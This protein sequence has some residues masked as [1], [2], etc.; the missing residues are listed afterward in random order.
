MTEQT[1]KL[2][3]S[4]TGNYWQIINGKRVYFNKEKKQ[5][6]EA[7]FLQSENAKINK[8]GKIQSNKIYIK[9]STSG[10]YYTIENG[11]R[12]YFAANGNEIKESYF[13]QQEGVKKNEKGQLVKVKKESV[14]AKSAK[15]IAKNLKK[16][17]DGWNDNDAIKAEMSKVDNAE[18]LKEL[19]KQ[20]SAAGYKADDMYSSVEKFLYEEL[21]ENSIGDNSFEYLEQLVQK[22]IQNGVLKGDDAIKAQARLAARIIRDGGDGMGTDKDEIK[23]GLHLIKT[24]KS[25][26]KVAQDEINVK[27]VYQE[28]QRI[29]KNAHN[30]TL[31]EYLVGEVS[32]DELKS[33]KGIMAQNSAVQ[34]KTK[35]QAIADLLIEAVEGAGTDV[36]ELKEALKGIK[37]PQDRVAI[38]A[39]L[40]KYCKEKGINGQIKGQN[41][42]QAIMYDELDGFA[43]VGTNHEEIRKFNEMMISQGA[44]N[45]TEAVSLRAQQAALQILEGDMDNIKDALE[46][47]KDKEVLKA[48]NALLTT[49][50]YSNIDAYLAKIGK[51][52]EEQDIANSI[53]AKK[54]MLTDEKAAEV[55]ARLLLNKDFD[56]KA[57]GIKSIVNENI[58]KLVDEILHKSNTSLAQ[59]LNDFNKDKSKYK[60][61]ATY[62]YST[63]G[64]VGKYIGDKLSENTEISNNLYVES[65]KQQINVSEKDKKGYDTTINKLESD[66]NKLKEDY[67]AVLDTQGVVSDAVDYF[68]SAYNLGTNRDDIEAR[69]AHEEESIRLYKLAAEGKLS[70]FVNGKEVPVTFEEIFKER[71]SMFVTGSPGALSETI[72]NLSGKET[73]EYNSKAIENV[74]KQGERMAAMDMAKDIISSS[75]IELN[76][77][78]KSNDEN[79][80]TIAVYNGVA[81]LSKLNPQIT[82]T[83]LGL[84]FNGTNILDSNGK[85]LSIEKLKEI[86]KSLKEDYSKISKEVFNKD[87]P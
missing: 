29:I 47:I 11:V 7:V 24:P 64:I 37:S 77:G 23:R 28:V 35:Q 67:Q 20:L 52:Q 40:Q 19:E 85:K 81:A 63:A 72:N 26:G 70:K 4:Q 6:D 69:I 38:N 60:L 10:R 57:N 76:N 65:S 16:A 22:W 12:H 49:K 42:I 51:T 66:L 8:D 34:G 5:I 86:A 48:V 31:E 33:L 58:A 68:A 9:G 74:A 84:Q 39:M 14:Q 15:I 45:K 32:E 53:L 59:I 80:L 62:F 78:L 73:T 75:W 50:G 36:E 21:D 54:K 27:K 1:F 55:A 43:G 18:E 87:I 44:Y 56:I 61:A 13:F 46:N 83:T 30:E 79:E 71:Q 82:L 2:K 17:T 3:N 25:T 41:A